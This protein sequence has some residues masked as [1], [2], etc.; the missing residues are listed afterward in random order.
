MTG[1]SMIHTPKTRH[2]CEEWPDMVD[3]RR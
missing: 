1:T 3:P 2:A